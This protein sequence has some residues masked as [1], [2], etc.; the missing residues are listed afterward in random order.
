MTVTFLMA[1][2]LASLPATAPTHG[3]PALLKPC[4]AA[5]YT[6]T[7]W[8]TIPSMRVEAP[9]DVKKPTSN[10]PYS[11]VVERLMKR[12]LMALPLP[13]SVVL[14]LPMGFQPEP[15]FQYVSPES[16][17]PLPL[18]SRSMSLLSS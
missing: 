11:W 4:V 13:L 16:A 17:R 8:N 6:S 7:S 18:V 2:P 9:S 10:C 12:P 14:K 5:P 1:P 3:S 15:L